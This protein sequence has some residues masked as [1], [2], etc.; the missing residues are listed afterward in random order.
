MTK[1]RRFGVHEVVKGPF[2]GGLHVSTQQYKQFFSELL[3]FSDYLNRRLLPTEPEEIQMLTILS[4]FQNLLEHESEELIKHYVAHHGTSQEQQF[5]SRI[6]SGYVSFKT[7]AD[8]ILARSLITQDCWEV[9]NEIRILRNAFVHSRPTE[10]RR[11]FKY[12]GFPVLTQRSLRR[13]FVDV[14]L[15]LRAIRAKCGR[16]CKWST[17]PPGYASEL[18]WP[19]EYIA[20][21]EGELGV[22]KTLPE[23]ESQH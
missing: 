9:M 15:N 13:M 19:S 1:P 17:V 4:N 16:H 7:K 2:A 22:N 3:Y 12:R 6:A 10:A 5:Q 20:V 8:W 21:L 11:R 18:H 14:E 23:S